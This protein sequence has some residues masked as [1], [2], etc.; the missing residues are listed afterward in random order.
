[1]RDATA[2][3]TDWNYNTAY[4]KIVFF[5]IKLRRFNFLQWKMKAS[6][7]NGITMYEWNICMNNA[8]VIVIQFFVEIFPN[9]MRR[10]VVWIID[11]QSYTVDTQLRDVRLVINFQHSIIKQMLTRLTNTWCVCVLCDFELRCI[12][13]WREKCWKKK[14]C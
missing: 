5:S 2:F 14:N 1:M 13:F 6:H 4:Y 7:L 11:T 3:L 9:E 10:V 8:Y 12:T